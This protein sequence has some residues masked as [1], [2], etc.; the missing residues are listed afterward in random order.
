MLNWL[1]FGGLTT[2]LVGGLIR[3]GFFMKNE[4][5]EHSIDDLLLSEGTM[6]AVKKYG[7]V[8]MVDEKGRSF[9]AEWSEPEQ[10]VVRVDNPASS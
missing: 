4:A 1:L 10:R 7:Y 3:V 2:L 9:R 5:P 8:T 6:H